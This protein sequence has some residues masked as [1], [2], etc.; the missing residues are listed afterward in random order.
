MGCGVLLEQTVDL[1]PIT[2]CFIEQ[3]S[4]CWVA[5]PKSALTATCFSSLNLI[6]PT[7]HSV[8]GA[9]NTVSLMYS[10]V[11]LGLSWA[12]PDPADAFLRV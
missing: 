3:C 5:R 11:W 8:S 4:D 9:K 10:P 6:F 2:S 1:S 7:V 12:V